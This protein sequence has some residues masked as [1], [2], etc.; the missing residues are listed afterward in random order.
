M[1][2]IPLFFQQQAAP[3]AGAPAAAAPGVDPNAAAAADPTGGLLGLIIPFGGMFAIMYFLIIRPQNQR[4]KKHKE[5]LAALKK[6]DTV[7]TSGGII[8]KV[9]KLSDDE[10]TLDTGDG[11]AKLR[12]VRAM[13][14]DVR[15][16]SAPPAANDV[17]ES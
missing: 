9:V 5:L 10:V 12:I 7:I 17:K 14:M 15:G 1:L 6:G 4:Q 13:I 8:G 2:P 16:Q 11:G 3:A